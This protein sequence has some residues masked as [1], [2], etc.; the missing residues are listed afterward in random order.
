MFV[1]TKWSPTVLVT[2]FKADH[3]VGFGTEPLVSR[4][5]P[6]AFVGHERTIA[7][8]ERVTASVGDAGTTSGGVT[9][10]QLVPM[11]SSSTMA[12][13]CVATA[14][15]NW[16]LRIWSAAMSFPAEVVKV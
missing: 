6:C 5:N 4:M 9:L 10:A 14:S 3:P 12:I 11:R 16:K 2:E 1:T 8:S 15:R 7:G 13:G